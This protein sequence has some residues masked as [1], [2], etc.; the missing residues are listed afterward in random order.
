MKKAILTLTPEAI[1]EIIQ[2][3]EG[4]QLAGMYIPFDRPG[5]VHLKV[6]GA[7]WETPEG[8][9]IQYAEGATATRDENGVLSIDWKLP[10][11]DNDK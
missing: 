4:S 3:P 1:R 6:E 8:S 2:I 9:P 7:G 11:N 5:V 10:E